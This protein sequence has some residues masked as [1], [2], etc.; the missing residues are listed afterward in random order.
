[1]KNAATYKAVVFDGSDYQSDYWIGMAIDKQTNNKS[2]EISSYW[3]K[4]FLTADFRTTSAQGTRRLALA[5]RKTIDDTHDLDIKEELSAAALLARSLDGQLINMENFADRFCLSEKSKEA[6]ASQLKFSY[7]RFDQ[8]KFSAAE[9]ANH[10]KYKSLQINNGALL[11]APIGRF[12]EC[13]K[14]TS[15]DKN[16]NEFIFSTQGVRGR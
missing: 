12:E 6:L 13:F 2:V 16:S 7:L 10:V 3:I 11:T 14:K 5:I 8:F 15:V 9:F 4:E 1:M